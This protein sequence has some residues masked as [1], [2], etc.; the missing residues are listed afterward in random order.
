MTYPKKRMIFHFYIDENWYDSITNRI[1]LECLK[2]YAPIFDE[3]I[4]VLSLNDKN[5]FEL[6]RSV[7]L[8][9]LSY[10]F[11]PNISFKI[12]E[13]T[14]LRE[15]KTFYDL[16][17]S[18]LDGYDGLTFF[19]HG[20]GITNLKNYEI[21]NV[22]I[23]ITALYFYSLEFPED[24][25]HS[26]TDGRELSYGPLLNIIIPEEIEVTEEG[27]ENKKKFVNRIN[28]FLG[29]HK[30]AYTGTFFWINGKCINEFMKKNDIELPVL[31]DRW[32]A[33][34][35]CSNIFNVDF[36]YSYKGGMCKN[37]LQEGAEIMSLVCN[38]CGD[39]ESIVWYEEF[40][41]N[42][43]EKIGLND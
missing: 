43:K 17:A 24:V 32:Y 28:V 37:Y 5:N 4:F 25:V 12:V 35:F 42:I 22:L 38:S 10:N 1:H 2:R 23:W 30:Y 11:T 6:I 8:E 29:K 27:V 20:K 15:A 21:E 33:E 9:L 39:R 19:A 16:I 36:A 31:S 40:K 34:N 26:L 41:N 7:E 14:Y 3:V 18:D 13:N